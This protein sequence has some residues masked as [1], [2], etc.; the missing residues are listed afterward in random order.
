[1]TSI[2][3]SLL[4]P[5]V[6]DSARGAVRPIVL[7]AGAL[8][9]A[10]AGMHAQ[11]PLSLADADLRGATIFER[12]G[13]TGMVL[14]VVRNRE[15]MMKGYG[16]ASPGSGA[17]P[18][19]NSL[20]RLCSISKVLAG[21]LL[22]ELANEGKVALTDPLQRFAPPNTT[23]PK[24]AG[25]TPI[26]LLELAT[27][28]AGLPR[29][30]GPY[31][32][33]TPHFTFPDRAFRWTWLPERRLLARPGTAASYSNVGFDLLGDALA[34]AANKPYAQLL[35]ERIVRPLGLH[36]TTLTPSPEQCTRLLLGA[37]DEGPCTNTEES[38][39]SGGVYSTAA[40]MARVLEY[41]L[42]VPGTSTRVAPA[43]T[44]YWKPSQLKSLRGLSHAGDPT[45]IGLGWIQLGNP[46]GPSVLMQKTGGGAG[47]LTYVALSVKRQTGIFVAV[48]DGKRRLRVDLF[49]EA[50]NL[51]AAV[52]N[53]PPLP[54][55]ARPARAARKRRSSVARPVKPP[56]Q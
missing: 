47:F 2:A 9:I 25:G 19:A 31:P 32:A 29:E 8:L 22:A 38:G 15:V 17:A 35:E 27:H 5:V 51:L 46:D 56:A 23:V 37:G 12:S 49:H 10:A 36:D 28:T 39:A 11:Q 54:P 24:G 52:A 43:M 50:N 33:D 44:V 1:M 7:L 34:S 13:A 40:D 26:T 48:T 14:V 53:V 16:E 21:D 55:R 3:R 45:G 41:L 18:N 6:D 4:T 20:I 30:V 42:H